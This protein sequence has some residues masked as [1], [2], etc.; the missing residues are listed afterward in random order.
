MRSA[1]LILAYFWLGYCLRQSHGEYWPSFL[2]LLCLVLLVAASQ[3][4]RSTPTGRPAT[5]W[6]FLTV[7]AQFALFSSFQG[8]FHQEQDLWLDW[9]HR[10]ET[11]IMWLSFLLLWSTRWT[12]RWILTLLVGE[13]VAR[14]LVPLQSPH[15]HIDVFTIATD[16]ADWLLQGHNP[17]AREYEDVYQGQYGYRAIYLYWPMTLLLQTVS[18]ALTGDVRFAFVATEALL[19]VLLYSWLPGHPMRRYLWI[20]MW[21]TFPPQLNVL[22]RA[23]IEPFMVFFWMLAIWLTQRGRPLAAGVALGCLCAVKQTAIFLPLLLLPHF[24]ARFGQR[25]TLQAMGATVLSFLAV[26]LPFALADWSWFYGSTIQA[27][28]QL[29]PRAD[30][31]NVQAY[32]MHAG[33]PTL[34]G[35]GYLLLLLATLAGLLYWIRRQP[36]MQRSL[37]A[38]FCFYAILFLFGKQAFLNYYVFLAFLLL[39]ASAEG[40]RES[41]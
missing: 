19:L 12:G 8:F 7:L 41:G 39:T 32:L 29:P 1:L 20:L 3:L 37:A 40:E 6:L 31:L 24:Y 14:I 36:T 18:R 22:E 23:W 5:P 13:I 27:L 2:A 10:V 11:K 9:L 16:G 35:P 4:L 30:S 21:L 38:A 28:A 34:S 33:L 15:P 25:R 17:Y 26:L